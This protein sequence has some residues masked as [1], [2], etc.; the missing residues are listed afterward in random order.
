MINQ[1]LEQ[2]NE[3]VVK[4]NKLIGEVESFDDILDRV[5]DKGSFVCIYDETN[6]GTVFVDTVLNQ[7]IMDGLKATL[8]ETVETEKNIKV[9]ELQN[10][11]KKSIVV[12]KGDIIPE[13]NIVLP[14]ESKPSGKKV[15]ELDLDQV[16]DMYVN[17]GLTLKSIADELGCAASTVHSFIKKNKITKEEVKTE[18]AIP[19]TVELVR[20]LYTDGTMNLSDTAKYFRVDSKVLHTFIEKHGLKKK[21]VKAN[22]PFLDANKM[23]KEDFKKKMMASRK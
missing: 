1:L 10:L 15:V 12:E 16:K 13:N 19:L 2:A 4:V 18:P 22:D 5:V 9:Q 17:K 8:V 23:S 7:N 3:H 20:E 14:K 21:V 11:I 6:G